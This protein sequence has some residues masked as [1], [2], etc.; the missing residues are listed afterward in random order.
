MGKARGKANGEVWKG[1]RGPLKGRGNGRA[2]GRL[3]KVPPDGN[4]ELG[5]FFGII[6]REEM[7]WQ[8]YFQCGLAKVAG[9]SK[10]E[11]SLLLNAKHNILLRVAECVADALGYE[12]E[13]LLQRARKRMEAAQCEASAKR[14]AERAAMRAALLRVRC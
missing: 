4:S 12:L 5:K 8:G 2:R 1:R 3:G 13:V 9:V 6:V 14:T 11:M 10:S 7:E